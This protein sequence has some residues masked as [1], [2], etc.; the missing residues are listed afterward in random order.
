[1]LVWSRIETDLMALDEVKPPSEARVW[2]AW[3]RR[4]VADDERYLYQASGPGIEPF[5]SDSAEAA[6]QY[7]VRAVNGDRRRPDEA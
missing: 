6:M 7:V 1:V 3:V 2:P 4:T 5:E